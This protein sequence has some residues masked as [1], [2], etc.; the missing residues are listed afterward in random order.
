MILFQLVG[1]FLLVMAFVSLGAV[2]GNRT[3]SM[4]PER[5]P[6][7]TSLDVATIILSWLVTLAAHWAGYRAALAA[8]IGAGIGLF[9]AFILHRWRNQS[10]RNEL[11]VGDSRKKTPESRSG[12]SPTASSYSADRLR[13]TWR[14]FVGQVGRFQNGLLLSVFYFIALAPFGIVAGTFGDPLGLKAP[15]GES[16]WKCREDAGQSLEGAHRQS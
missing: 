1:F 3:K 12:P 9:E 11:R 8:A 13:P 7:P 14:L 15:P 4:T 10:Q 6:S 5:I 2:A 16:F